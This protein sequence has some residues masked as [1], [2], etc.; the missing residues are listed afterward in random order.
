[1]LVF[2]IESSSQVAGAAIVDQDKVISE[3]T[4][5]KGLTHS[6]VLMP[7]IDNVFKMGD[8]DIADIDVFAVSKGP[9]SFT[10]LRIGIATTK[11]LAQSMN[12][13]IIGVP[14]LDG[15]A[16]NIQYTSHIICPIL[17]ARRE[18]VYTS[19]Y[20]YEDDKLSRMEE[21]MAIS[22]YDL[23]EKLM[24]EDRRVVFTG[25]GVGVYRDIIENN[26]GD[27]ALFAPAP[28]REQ[29]ASSIA[30]I[31]MDLASRGDTEDF[32]AL[33]PFY[34]RKSQAEQSRDRQKKSGKTG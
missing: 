20:Q 1:M 22:L 31:A 18:Q 10:G 3:C 25:D 33:K 21:Y 16:Y 8:I 14:T 19:V 15:L 29:R 5:N 27:R 24:G 7:L 2:A 34:L 26:M 28:F 12:K 11:G 6:E 23:M 13:P 30:S 9:G 32:R 17:N 4:L